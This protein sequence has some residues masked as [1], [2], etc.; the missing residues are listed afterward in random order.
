MLND[1]DML[2]LMLSSSCTGLNMNVSEDENGWSW[3]KLCWLN[4]GDNINGFVIDADGWALIHCTQ[5]RAPDGGS[6]ME[7]TNDVEMYGCNQ[8]LNL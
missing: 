6:Y 2:N 3:D 1:K 7:T 4:E 8:V 5:G